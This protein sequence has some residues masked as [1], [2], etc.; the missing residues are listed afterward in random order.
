MASPEAKDHDLE[1]RGS[2]SYEY[3]EFSL[4]HC[5]NVLLLSRI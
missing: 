4:D 5:R 1:S 2:E 3:D